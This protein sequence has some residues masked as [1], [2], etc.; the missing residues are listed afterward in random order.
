MHRLV[1]ALVLVP[2]LA[3]LTGCDIEEF[4]GVNQQ[5]EDFQRS[6][7]MKP[8]G[9]L[10][11]E[12]FNGSIEIRGGEGDTVEISGTKYA[13]TRELLDAVKID[14]VSAADSVRIRTVRPTDRRGNMGA[15]YVIRVPRRTEI[16]RAESSNGSIRVE[17]IDGNARLK[18]SNG[19]VRVDRLKGSLEAQTSNGRVELVE[20]GGAAIVRT[21]NGSIRADAIR[22][23]FDAT[24]SNGRIEARIVEPEAHKPI[25]MS[26]S[27]GSIEVTVDAL[28]D[29]EIRANT[30]N[31]S[32]TLRLPPTVNATLKARTNNASIQSDID[33]KGEGV[34]MSKNLAEGL[35]GSGGPL[36]DLSTSNGSIRL[37]RR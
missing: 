34:K 24:T 37:L 19:T 5:K 2:A 18:T 4:G 6:L 13:P 3:L 16:E 9:R 12:S 11:V 28:S 33:L 23:A 25:K 26:T 22:G 10:S 32:I 14:I 36:I 21:S 35:L 31:A 29:N 30:S 27:N 1:F 15:R 7:Q 8:G 17:T 20:H